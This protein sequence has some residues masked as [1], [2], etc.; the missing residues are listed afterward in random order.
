MT[1]NR[2]V[3]PPWRLRV[4]RESPLLDEPAERSEPGAAGR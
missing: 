1:A 3:A 2:V 4:D